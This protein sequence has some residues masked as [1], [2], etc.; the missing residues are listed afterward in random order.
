MCSDK[1]ED[2]NLLSRSPSMVG[3]HASP[4]ATSRSIAPSNTHYVQC[5]TMRLSH[6]N[7]EL[8]GMLLLM[9]P[10][11]IVHEI[12]AYSPLMPPPMWL[13]N[14]SPAP[15][16]TARSVASDSYR[17]D[18]V[19]W[20]PPTY[21]HVLHPFQPASPHEDYLANKDGWSSKDSPYGLGSTSCARDDIINEGIAEVG[22]ERPNG[23]L[24]RAFST[25]A[26]TFASSSPLL[27][28]HRSSSSSSSSSIARAR[29]HQKYVE[30]Y[31]PGI[32]SNISFPN[33]SKRASNECD[34]VKIRAPSAC[35]GPFLPPWPTGVSSQEP[36]ATADKDIIGK[37]MFFQSNLTRRHSISPGTEHS[38]SSSP[39]IPT[40]PSVIQSVGPSDTGES[41]IELQAPPLYPSIGLYDFAC[42]MNG[43]PALRKPAPAARKSSRGKPVPSTKQPS[44]ERR[45][46]RL[47]WQDEEKAMIQRYM[48]DRQIEV[49]AVVEGYIYFH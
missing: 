21:D 11:V 33:V 45:R 24:R 13:P 43:L 47:R 41:V 39:P 8:G 16:S 26:S 2:E 5:C 20:N 31:H 40:P 27:H 49:I 15:P 3:S 36:A 30:L 7:D 4:A 29:H 9:T 44:E 12:D 14:V 18:S 28:Q 42:D 37:R 35:Q 10:Q 32:L 17:D 25:S 34:P 22:L 46:V 23:K 48:K 38:R 19:R 6:P 1:E